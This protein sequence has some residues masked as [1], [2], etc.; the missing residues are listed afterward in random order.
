M[1]SWNYS[2]N[3]INWN[4]VESEIIKSISISHADLFIDDNL[5]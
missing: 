1:E 5:L 4:V 2:N 3:W